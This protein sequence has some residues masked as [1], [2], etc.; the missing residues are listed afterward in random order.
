MLPSIRENF[1]DIVLYQTT[2]TLTTN[3]KKNK[4]KGNNM[5]TNMNMNMNRRLDRDDPA[6]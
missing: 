1:V 5:N 4:L 6:T 3:V 2:Q